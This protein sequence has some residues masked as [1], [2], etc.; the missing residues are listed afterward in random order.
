MKQS[1]TTL[2]HLLDSFRA[3]AKTRREMGRYFEDL[4]LIHF[5]QDAKPL[6]CYGLVW[7]F[8]D[9]A[10]EYGHVPMDTGVDLVAEVREEARFCDPGKVL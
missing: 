8:R 6:S 9:Q 4:A 2:T 1:T 3:D 10:K 5:R 7:Q